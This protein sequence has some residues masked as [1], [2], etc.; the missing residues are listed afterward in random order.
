MSLLVTSLEQ[1]QRLRYH[2]H[3]SIP[4]LLALCEGNPS[5]TDGFPSQ[6][7]SNVELPIATRETLTFLPSVDAV[8]HKAGL[9]SVCDELALLKLTLGGVIGVMCEACHPLRDG[10]DTCRHRR[11][12]RNKC[13]AGKEILLL[14]IHCGQNKLAT[15]VQSTFS[16][17][18]PVKKIF[19]NCQ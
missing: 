4:P 2:R 16:N 10:N 11:Q 14:M 18:F 7:A 13:A 6:R 15:I 9:Y 3:Q 8:H 12:C 1:L 5:I 19:P 17:T